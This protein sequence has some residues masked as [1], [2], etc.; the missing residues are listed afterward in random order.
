MDN[1]PIHPTPLPQEFI[2]HRVIPE[3]I[4]QALKQIE[5]TTIAL[6]K[7]QSI[8]ALSVKVDFFSGCD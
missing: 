8:P 3:A 2:N 5:L 6:I 1:C 4:K 7:N